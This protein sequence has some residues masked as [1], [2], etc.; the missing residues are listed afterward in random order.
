MNNLKKIFVNFFIIFLHTS[1]SGQLP[2]INMLMSNK[3]LLTKG[4]CVI[5][6]H[7]VHNSDGCKRGFIW[8]SA[9]RLQKSMLALVKPETKLKWTICLGTGLLLWFV[10]VVSLDLYVQ[11][12][13]IDLKSN[14]TH[15]LWQ[16]VYFFNRIFFRVPFFFFL[17][18]CTW[19]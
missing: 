12:P 10:T 11:V 7:C 17:I 13:S 1:V 14:L 5:S 19:M 18:S 9:A 6:A 4:L 16:N 3:I 8:Y 15:W 2:L